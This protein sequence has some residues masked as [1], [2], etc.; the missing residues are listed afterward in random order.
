MSRI[1]I[2]VSGIKDKIK[3][4]ALFSSIIILSKGEGIGSYFTSPFEVVLEG[5]KES[6]LRVL[7]ELDATVLC[8]LS[9]GIRVSM[10]FDGDTHSSSADKGVQ[11]DSL[12]YRGLK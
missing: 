12:K 5:E 11:R 9:E 6:L 2:D 8:S 3:R 4:N 7:D 10:T 1:K